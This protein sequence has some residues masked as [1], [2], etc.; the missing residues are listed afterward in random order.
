[1]IKDFNIADFTLVLSGGGA[2]GIAHLGVLHDL[3]KHNILP[4][5]IVGTSMGGIIGACIS[6]G[7]HEKEIHEHI[8]SFAKIYNWIKFSFSGNAIVDSDKIAMIFNDIFHNRKMNETQIPLKLIAT[9][10]LNGHKRVFSASDEDIYIKDALLSTMAIPGIFDE[11]VIDGNTYGDGFL[12]ENLGINEATLTDVLAVDVLGENSFQKTMPDNFFKT[13]N[14]LEM[15]ERSIRLLIY[16][17]TRTHIRNS[18]K[19]IYLL[20]PET[21]D[22]KTFHFHKVKEIRALGLNLL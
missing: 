7:M 2:L 9:N 6:I 1:M 12:C 5:E 19:N 21:K 15:F 17:Q 16:N 8:K 13:A 14:V 20:E 18:D 11:H 3:E 10:L 4:Q 22:Y